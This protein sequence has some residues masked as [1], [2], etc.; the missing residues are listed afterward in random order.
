MIERAATATLGRTIMLVMAGHEAHG[1]NH[2]TVSRVRWKFELSHATRMMNHPKWTL[3]GNTKKARLASLKRSSVS[4]E[5][6]AFTLDKLTASPKCKKNS[7][8]TFHT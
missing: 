1:L 3:K 7:G 8:S 5:N 2:A 6:G 4:F